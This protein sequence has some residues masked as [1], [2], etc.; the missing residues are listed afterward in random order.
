M[1]VGG[2]MNA[3]LLL[4]N[5]VGGFALSAATLPYGT[6]ALA[7]DFNGDGN[8]AL[9]LGNYFL[10]GNGA[11]GFGSPQRAGVADSMFSG[12]SVGDF[13]STVTWISPAFR[14]A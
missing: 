3:T 7:A 11:G 8:P 13:N 9:V 6:F 1:V 14:M 10:P 5:G 2:N 12:A 4:G